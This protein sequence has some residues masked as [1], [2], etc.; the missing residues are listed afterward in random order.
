V[1]RGKQIHP[2]AGAGSR[3][4]GATPFPLDPSCSSP[5]EKLMRFVER[6]VANCGSASELARR[7]RVRPA[8]VSQWRS[9]VKRPDALHLI[10]IQEIASLRSLL[11]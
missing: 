5:E 1:E 9:G 11:G 8:T 4:W 10:R 7:L 6:A 2:G 3:S